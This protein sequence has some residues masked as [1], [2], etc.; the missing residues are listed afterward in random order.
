[1]DLYP[2]YVNGIF[3]DHGKGLMLSQQLGKIRKGLIGQGG[4]PNGRDADD[5]GPGLEVLRITGNDILSS[6][7]IAAELGCRVFGRVFQVIIFF[8]A[9]EY[10]GAGKK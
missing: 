10:T 5:T 1:M 6:A 3:L 9:G 7:V 8:G 2:L 4:I